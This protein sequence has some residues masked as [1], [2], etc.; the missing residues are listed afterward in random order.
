VELSQLADLSTIIEAIA[1]VVT[2]IA[3]FFQLRQTNKIARTTAYQNLCDTYN[4]FICTV[5]QSEQ[6][7]DLFYRTGRLK[8]ETLDATQ[9]AQFFFV[10]TLYFGF[11]ENLFIQKQNGILP[12]ELYQGW[13]SALK[14]NLQTP[15]FEAYWKREKR[16]Y[17][18]SFRVY[19]DDCLLGN[20]C[21]D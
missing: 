9:E 2:L 6:L 5:V 17:V 4:Q 18:P 10:A 15:G 12:R 11:H 19:V 20:G 7:S 13:K 16:E 8:P 3:L 14:Y 21:D 1:V